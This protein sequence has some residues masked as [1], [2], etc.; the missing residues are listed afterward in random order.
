MVDKNSRGLFNKFSAIPAHIP[1][2][3][4]VLS[5]VIE[6]YLSQVNPVYNLTLYSFMMER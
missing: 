1:G 5:M 4:S 2:R 6:P 3:N